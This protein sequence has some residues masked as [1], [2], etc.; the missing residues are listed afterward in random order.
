MS[1]QSKK[2]AATAWRPAAIVAAM[3]VAGLQAHAQDAAPA[4]AVQQVTVTGSNVR[5]TDSETPSPV[6]VLSAEDIRNSGYT[7]VGD[8]LHTSRPTT[9]ARCRSRRPA[10]SRP[11]AAASRCAG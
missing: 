8:V 11:A 3:Q 1:R 7:S 10:P 4:P 9:W 6:Q 5:R 2:N